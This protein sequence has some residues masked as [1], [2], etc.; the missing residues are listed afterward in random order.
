MSN[1]IKK[2]SS[3]NKIGTGAKSIGN[4]AANPKKPPKPPQIQCNAKAV[5]DEVRP[6]SMDCN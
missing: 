1:I 4:N 5:G 3:K 6:L 2:E